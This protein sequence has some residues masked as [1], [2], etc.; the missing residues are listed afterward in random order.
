[1][2][3]AK[4]PNEPSQAVKSGGGFM[5][6][7]SPDGSLLLWRG[8]PEAKSLDAARPSGDAK[9]V[10][11]ELAAALAAALKAA[12]AGSQPRHVRDGVNAP[13]VL[14]RLK[15]G[16]LRVDVRVPGISGYVAAKAGRL[17]PPAVAA[18]GRVWEAP[19][20]VFGAVA[21]AEPAKKQ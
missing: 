8:A 1:M 4:M 19:A 11:A 13:A 17:S 9:L 7:L 3:E 16:R 6:G 18:L 12:P 14:G 2:G 15:S 5:V 21:P 10:V 20:P